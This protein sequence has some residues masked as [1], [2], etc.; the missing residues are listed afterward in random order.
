[1]TKVFIIENNIYQT[2]K[3]NILPKNIIERVSKYKTEK[4][5][6]NSF[7]AWNYL[8]KILEEE[9]NI[10]NPIIYENDYH[11][12]FIEGIN[13]NISHSNNLIAVAISKENVGIDIEMVNSIKDLSLIKQKI[14]D[15]V[16][17]DDETLIK[18]WTKIEAKFK[19]DGSGIIYSKINNLEIND[20]ETIKIHDSNNCLYYLSIKSKEENEFIFVH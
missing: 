9:Y 6:I 8:L 19:Y 20:I 14:F 5:Y 11:K 15:D 10:I 12:P 17:I 1:M 4:D 13:F 18:K 7:V 3:N 2:I 16:N